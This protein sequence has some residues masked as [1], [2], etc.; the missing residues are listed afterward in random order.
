MAVATGLTHNKGHKAVLDRIKRSSP[1]APKRSTQ[2]ETPCGAGHVAAMISP[3]SSATTS[4]SI[5]RSGRAS[6]E[7]STMVSAG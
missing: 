5:I 7:T 3:A 4:I 2:H 1:Y 6:E